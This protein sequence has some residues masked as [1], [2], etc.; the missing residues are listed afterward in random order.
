MSR[1]IILLTSVYKLFTKL[2]SVLNSIVSLYE[3]VVILNTVGV[4][5]TKLWIII[6]MRH[7]QFP[8]ILSHMV[9]T[10]RSVINFYWNLQKYSTLSSS[11]LLCYFWTQQP[12]ILGNWESLLCL[13]KTYTTTLL[14]KPKLTFSVT[15]WY[16]L[17]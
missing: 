6:L 15:T 5:T 14:T 7:G 8:Q 13:R 4:S 1:D 16:T 12:A 9:A 17:N 10:F 11:S 2:V 3:T